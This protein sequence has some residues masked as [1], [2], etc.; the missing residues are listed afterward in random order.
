MPLLRL[1]V[2]TAP[3]SL[4]E[5]ILQEVRKDHVKEVLNSHTHKRPGGSVCG[6]LEPLLDTWWDKHMRG[7]GCSLHLD[8]SFKKGDGKAVGPLQVEGMPSRREAI[9]AVCLQALTVLLSQDA[10]AT[11]LVP[12]HFRYGLQSIRQIRAAARC[13]Q[14][15]PNTAATGAL[16]P[17]VPAQQRPEPQQQSASQCL[18]PEP[19]PMGTTPAKTAPAQKQPR[20]PQKQP[21]RTAPVVQ[22]QPSMLEQPQPATPVAPQQLQAQGPK[23]CVSPHVGPAGGTTSPGAS[24]FGGDQSTMAQHWGSEN[25]YSG[26]CSAH[27]HWGQLP[28]CHKC[29]AQRHWQSAY[30]HGTVML[31]HLCCGQS[32]SWV[33]WVAVCRCGSVECEHCGAGWKGDRKCETI[34]AATKPSNTFMCATALAT[35]NSSASH[36]GAVVMAE[37]RPPVPGGGFPEPAAIDNAR[38]S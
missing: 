33:H 24:A 32:E 15:S 16:Q 5:T 25:W 37:G 31:C 20:E 17:L 6:H 11:H 1:A 12:G 28:K 2:D 14:T 7:Y 34:W 3:A 27:S 18:Q 4:R 36:N 26:W 23:I 30:M 8:A 35:S 10:D 13:E 21:A 9:Q 29:L 22:Q 38:P 19:P